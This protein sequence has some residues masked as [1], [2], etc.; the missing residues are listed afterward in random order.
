MHAAGFTGSS[1]ADLLTL[2]YLQ[3]KPTRAIL[4]AGLFLLLF[5]CCITWQCTHFYRLA[6]NILFDFSFQDVFQLGI[7][8]LPV[9]LA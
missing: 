3:V 7:F 8:N 9:G 2:Q 6:R 1:Y 4:H 5:S